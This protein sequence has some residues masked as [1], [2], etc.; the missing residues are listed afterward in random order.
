M[1]DHGIMK[2]IIQTWEEMQNISL[3]RYQEYCKA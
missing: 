3:K 2:N 1:L